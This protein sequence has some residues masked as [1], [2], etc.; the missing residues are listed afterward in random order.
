[1]TAVL[2]PSVT[3]TSIAVASLPPNSNRIVCSPTGASSSRP[4]ERTL[5]A[6]H[7]HPG[8]PYWGM[9]PR[10]TAELS[11]SVTTMSMGADIFPPNLN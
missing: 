5:P 4:G 7:G 2:P 8:A 9:S 11:P 3:T 6:S 10:I 1:M